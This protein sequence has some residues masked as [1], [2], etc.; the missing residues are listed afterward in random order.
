MN[1]D[2]FAHDPFVAL[3]DAAVDA[4]IV[5]D[6]LGTIRVVN[7]AVM[8]LFGYEGK[9]MIGK[10]VKMLMPKTDYD[11]HDSYLRHYHET[12]RRKIIGIGREV[13]GQK[14]DDSC[15]PMYLSVGR[16]EGEKEVSF[17]GI[18]RD[19]T[20]Q[21]Q[22]EQEVARNES[23]I[24]QL[25]ERLIHVARI[26]TLGE[27]VT[28][29]AHEVNQPLTAIATYA[30]GCTRMINGGLEDP[31][32]LLEALD[33]MSSQ[34]ERAAKVITRIRNFSKKS[35]IVQE[36]YDCNALIAEVAALAEVHAAEMDASIE[37]HLA[38]ESRL[39]VMVDAT[40][41]QQVVLNLINNAIESMVDVNR[42]KIV[43]IRTRKLDE[44]TI[45]VSVSD[46]GEGIDEAVEER[47]FDAFFTT[48]SAGLG[49]GLS[50]CQSL[51]NAQGGA[52]QF[53]RNPHKGCTF[54][55][56]LPTAIGE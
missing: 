17:V 9:E 23:E 15:F 48:K 49:I 2:N 55:F 1:Q 25:R 44:D 30:Q 32:E 11:H 34:A 10:N 27:M 37:L 53:H 40:Q 42:E 54:C 35:Q 12:G 47:V 51:V 3:L 36:A 14:K 8:R 5:I 52:I 28:G 45:E 20:A 43:T 41:V 39:V 46:L 19:L 22:K 4:I 13:I 7:P 21:Q 18:I 16:I 31:K 26:S 50:I 33:K 24:R 56:T 6:K 29:I 38:E